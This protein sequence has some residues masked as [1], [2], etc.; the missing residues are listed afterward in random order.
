MNVLPE[1]SLM[2]MISLIWLIAWKSLHFVSLD[3]LKDQQSWRQAFALNP[4]TDIILETAIKLEQK[5]VM[6]RT[7]EGV[8]LSSLDR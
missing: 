4:K 2:K 5:K 1:K 8:Q 6:F 3:P 7:S